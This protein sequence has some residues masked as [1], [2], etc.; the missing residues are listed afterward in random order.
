VLAG[1]SYGVT[2]LTS[3]QR[4]KVEALLIQQRGILSVSEHDIGR[5]QL[6]EHRIDTG[7]ARLIR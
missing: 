1:Y 3:E 2:E 6:V 7:D 5:T 4:A